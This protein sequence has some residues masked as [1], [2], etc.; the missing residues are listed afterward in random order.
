MPGASVNPA[1]RSILKPTCS[2]WSH[3]SALLKRTCGGNYQAQRW[4]K[5]HLAFVIHRNKYHS[6]VSKCNL[7]QFSHPQPTFSHLVT[8]RSKQIS[9]TGCCSEPAQNV[10]FHLNLTLMRRLRQNPT[11]TTPPRSFTCKPPRLG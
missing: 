10:Y 9:T 5:N 6:L 1:M 7:S 4:K 2:Q 11:V 3:F 8:T